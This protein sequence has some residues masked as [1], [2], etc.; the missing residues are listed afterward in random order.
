[1]KTYLL[2]ILTLISALLAS[3]M[4]E[5]ELK[6]SVFIYDPENIDLPAYSEWGY[7]TFGAYYDRELFV[8]NDELVP[9]KIIVSDTSFS[10]LLDGQKGSSGY[11]YD[12]S[13][14]LI[15]FT[16]SGFM[17]EHFADL[18]LFN[19][20]IIDLTNSSCHVFVTIDTMKYAADILSGELN[21]KRVQILQV[22]K[23]QVEAILSGYFD[24]KAIINHKPITISDG[25]FDVGIGA[26]NF[27][28]K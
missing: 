26:D 9:A 15:S 28:G 27:Y 19:D 21:F 17:P 2:T 10:F 24:F 1:M 4:K 16:L 8:S 14:M 20:S 13:E 6:K 18:A 5:N 25:R 12:Y 23:Q 7:N 11:Y 3:C 22:D